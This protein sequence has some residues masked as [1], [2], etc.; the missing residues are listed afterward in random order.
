MLLHI[1]KLEEGLQFC[2]TI[3]L[4]LI[5][6]QISNKL[7]AIVDMARRL[8]IIQFHTVNILYLPA[9]GSL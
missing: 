3:A 6:E 9:C 4:E 7:V 8:C 2:T 1:D 5:H